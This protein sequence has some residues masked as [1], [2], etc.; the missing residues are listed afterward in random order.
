M[1]PRTVRA[2][3]RGPSHVREDPVVTEEPLEIVVGH[4]GQPEPWNALSVTMRTPG[5]DVDLAVGFLFDEGLIAQGADVVD[6]R[7]E[8]VP[9]GTR[10]TVAVAAHVDLGA[11]ADRSGVTTSACGVCGKTALDSLGLQTGGSVSAAGRVRADSI[12]TLPRTLLAAQ[13]A[14]AATGGLHAAGLFDE[15]GRLL[16]VREDVGRHN[17][18][19]KVVGAALQEG[20][21]PFREPRVLV[22]SGRASF[23]LAHKARR[24]GVVVLAAV[25]APSSLAVDVARAAGMTLLGFV[26]DDRFNVYCGE[27]RVD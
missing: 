16:S 22:V 10:V 9:N 5:H 11:A 15:E 8:A 6:A 17:A 2:F 23:E 7:V 4:A 25:G 21:L 27:E 13:T 1:V 18:V 19:D 20:P 12:G 26:R 14:F 24:A 3:G